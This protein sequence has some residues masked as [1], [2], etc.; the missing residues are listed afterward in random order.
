MEPTG[1]RRIEHDKPLDLR[2][3]LRS[4]QM[5]GADPALQL[6]GQEAA[7]AIRSPEGPVSLHIRAT[8]GI[9]TAAGWGPGT[10]WAL[11]RLD[12][13]VGLNDDAESFAPTDPRVRE[14]QRRNPGLRLPKIHQVVRMLIPIVLEQ[15]VSGAE[16]RRAFRHIERRVAEDAPGPLGLRLPPDPAK[17]A[18]MP[19]E[20]YLACTAL[21]KQARTIKRLC[22]VAPRLEEA[23][24]M[25]FVE[26]ARRLQALRGLG[27]WSAGSA[28]LRGMGFADAIILGDY[29]FPHVVGNALAGEPEADDRRMVE[30]LKPFKG[31]RG[32]V[33]RLITASAGGYGPRKAPRAPIRTWF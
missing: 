5:S 2:A 27:P 30:L 9:V 8:P 31:H 25:G 17:L 26:A 3:T 23:T 21:G 22:A 1:T 12:D 29:H 33:M 10:G 18:A 13:F 4:L 15:L 14:W 24:H 32:R 28:M 6:R 7:W 16:A 11:D 19:V 20:T